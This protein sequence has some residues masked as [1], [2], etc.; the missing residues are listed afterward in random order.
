MVSRFEQ[1]LTSDAKSA[2]E[3]GQQTSAPGK[4]QRAVGTHPDNGHTA[5][6]KAPSLGVHRHSHSCWREYQR[7]SHLGKISNSSTKPNLQLHRDPAVPEGK[8]P[9]SRR[10]ERMHTA[11]PFCFHNQQGEGRRRGWAVTAGRYRLPHT[12]GLSDRS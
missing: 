9:S 6:K 2:H 4:R 7:Y 12:V 5:K 1:K 3:R 10:L 11:A 8:G